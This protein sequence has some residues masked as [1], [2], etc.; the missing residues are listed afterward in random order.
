M[1]ISPR[2]F[3][4]LDRDGTVIVERNYLSDYRLVEL[5]PGAA[6]GLRQIEDMGLGCL[7][8]TNQSGIGRG[9]FGVEE[10]DLVHRRMLE[11]LAGEGISVDGIFYCPHNPDQ[12]GCSCRKPRIGLIEQAVARFGFDPS[13]CFVIGDKPCDIE[14]GRRVQAKTLLVRTGYG[15]QMEAERI[16]APDWIVDDLAEAATVI[17]NVLFNGGQ[18]IR[19]SKEVITSKGKTEII[20]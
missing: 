15:A 17:N 6:V 10:L 19:N 13:Q 2:H 4:L 20:G 11:L 7:I 16:T 3:V 8:I 9:Y 18:P 5:L 1:N 12:Q 14:M